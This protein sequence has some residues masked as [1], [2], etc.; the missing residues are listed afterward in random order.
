MARLRIRTL[1][2]RDAEKGRPRPAEVIPFAGEQIDGSFLLGFTT[3]LYEAKWFKSP[4]PA[5][6][7]YQFKGKLDGKFAGTVGIVISMS[8]YSADAVDALSRGKDQKI[9]LLDDS[10]VASV[11]D[12]QAKFKDLLLSRMRLAAH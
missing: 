11:F 1:A 12:G 2:P 6:A 7:I 4:V 9:I 5:S 10:D 8:G 3:V